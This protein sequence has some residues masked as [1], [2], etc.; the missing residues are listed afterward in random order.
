MNNENDLGGM[1]GHYGYQHYNSSIM[2]STIILL[3]I[4]RVIT[5]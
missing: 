5:Q 1:K 4:V 3:I 2:I